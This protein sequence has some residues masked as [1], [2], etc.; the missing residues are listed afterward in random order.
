MDVLGQLATAMSSP[1]HFAPYA[2]AALAVAMVK[3]SIDDPDMRAA[4]FLLF[5][6]IAQVCSNITKAIFLCGS[7]L[8]A[9][10]LHK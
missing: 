9:A 2:E 7:H 5:G 4:T 8:M 6:S 10:A 1:T 3:L